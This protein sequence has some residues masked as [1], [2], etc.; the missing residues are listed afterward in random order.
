[1]VTSTGY[2]LVL[3]DVQHVPEVKLNLTSAGR[4]DDKGHTGSIRNDVMKFCKGGLIVAKARKT[5]TLYLMHTLLCHNKV[6]VAVDTTG[7]MWHKR[8]CHMSED[9]NN[10]NKP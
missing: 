7:E 2:N 10:R 8:L 5:N 6:N 9:I 1:M 3:R 4:L